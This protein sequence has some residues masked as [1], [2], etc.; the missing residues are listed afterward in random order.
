MKIQIII[1]LVF[2]FLAPIQAFAAE[3]AQALADKSEKMVIFFDENAREIA[4][5]P[6]V[7]GQS[8]G[9]K[10][11]EG[12]KR[13]PEGD[14]TLFPARPSEEWGYFMPVDYPNEKDI[15]RAK[16]RGQ[17][18]NTLGGAVG[19]HATGGKFM[20]RVRQSF[21]ENWTLGCIAVTDDD[22]NRIRRFV[23]R[24]IPLRIQP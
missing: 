20:H 14:Y 2:L 21:G 16:K 6:A 15:M 4:R 19:M 1:I 11:R 22:M 9:S 17:P 10:T 12:D 7:F 23:D 18:L 5:Y 24:P 3:A 13:T 8:A